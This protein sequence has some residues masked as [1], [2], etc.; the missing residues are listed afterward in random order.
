M[1]KQCLLPLAVTCI[2]FSGA[3]NAFKLL[4]PSWENGSVTYD[5]SFPGA[6]PA[7]QNWSSA[8]QQAA[9]KWG[10]QV[11]GL[12]ITFTD[13]GFHACAGYTGAFPEDGNQNA[14]GFYTQACDEA[15]GTDVIAV[16]LSRSFGSFYVESDI[17]F[18]SNESWSVYDGTTQSALDF[19]RVAVHEFGHLIGLDHEET[20]SAIMAP[21]IGSIFNPTTDDLNGARDIYSPATGGGGNSGGGNSTPAIQISLEEPSSNQAANGVTNIR[22]WAVGIS[23][24]QRIELY[25]NG[26]YATNI[27]YGGDRAD[28]GQRFP[29]YQ[30][31]SKS[32]FSMIFNWGNLPA[33]QHNMEVRAYDSA[34]R[35][36]S[37]SSNFT[38]HAFDTAFISDPSQVQILSSATV[39][40]NNTITLNQVRAE[41]KN[42]KV[43]LRWNT[44][45]Q[46]WDVAE[47]D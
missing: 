13:N 46:K 1:L 24:I 36:E 5:T 12:N 45:T 25:V 34:G 29:S 41:G 43:V 6:T 21:F 9:N 10:D 35:T 26:S 31:S 3:S 39:S 20:N 22:G 32:G 30:N 4:G 7:G 47:I 11:E 27:P 16:T 42:Y 8:M 18:N 28:V 38:V 14:S 33:G 15:F 2:V 17:V 44:A 40:G 23:T 19:R 37:T